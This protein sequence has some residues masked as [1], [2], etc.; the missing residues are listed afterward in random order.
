[1]NKKEYLFKSK[2]KKFK[3]ILITQK[4]FKKILDIFKKNN[5]KKIKI[6]I[7]KSGCA[8]FKYIFEKYI[9]KKKTDIVFFKKNINIIVSKKKI[10]L[11]DGIKIDYIKKK[12]KTIFKFFHKK[13]QNTC[14]CGESFKIKNS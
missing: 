9:K 12:F 3:G 1:M 10:H 11:I 7:K 5:I 13:I 8:G 6:N 2:K 14:G 4:A